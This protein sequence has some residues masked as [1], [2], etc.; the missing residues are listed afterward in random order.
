MSPRSNDSNASS[1]KQKKKQ[2]HS[3]APAPSVSLLDSSSSSSPDALLSDLDSTPASNQPSPDKNARVA[4][5]ASASTAPRVFVASTLKPVSAIDSVTSTISALSHHANRGISNLIAAHSISNNPASPLIAPTAAADQLATPLRTDGSVSPIYDAFHNA[6]STPDPAHIEAA[7]H[8]AQSSQPPPPRVLWSRWDR[9]PLKSH[10]LKFAPLLISYYD[11]GS[12]QALL[13]QDRTMSE[14]L[15]LPNA[16]DVL[17]DRPASVSALARPQILTA[18]VRPPSANTSDPQ[19]L[20]V[21][22]EPDDATCLLAYALTSH[23][24]QASVQLQ[25]HSVSLLQAT[26]QHEP[27]RNVLW[28]HVQAQCNQDYLV[29]SFAAPA[30]IHVLSP[31]TLEYLRSPILEVAAAST[32]RP[33]PVSLSHRLLAF[34]CAASKD[35]SPIR[36]D[37]RKVSNPAYHDPTR[38]SFAAMPSDASPRV[39]EMRDNL[40]ETSAHMGDAARR[41]RGGVMS[42]VRTLGEWG[43][44]YWPQ[45]GSPPA[46][47]AA[48]SPPQSSLLSQSAPH[49][50]SHLPRQASSAS[51]SPMLLAADG[52]RAAKRLSTGAPA[53]ANDA[54]AGS[55]QGSHTV[56]AA[57]VRVID[58]ASDARTICTFAPSNHAVTLVAFSPCGRLILTADTLGHAFHVFELPLS[59][60][61]GSA[62]A[63][64]SSSP[65]LHRYKL[66]RGITTAD[67]V[68]AQWTPDAQ[69]VAVG[70]HSG[71]VHIY[72]V[73]PFGGIPSIANHVQAKI[74][75][76]HAPQ[77][78]GLSLPSL[79]RSVR[80]SAP[81]Q[82]EVPQK[83]TSG[84]APDAHVATATDMQ[85]KM[86]PPSFLL[87][88]RALRAS[89]SDGDASSPFELLTSDPRSVSVTLH[90]IRC[91][92][93]QTRASSGSI[94]SEDV[95]VDS[96]HHLVAATSPRASGLS[97]MMRKAGEGLLPNQQAPRLQAECVRVALWDQLSPDAGSFTK[98]SVAPL[99]DQTS[100]SF[101]S[102]RS[103]VSLAKSLTSVAKA[104][105]ETYSQSPAMLPSSIFLSRQ[106]FF[107]ARTRSTK[108]TSAATGTTDSLRCIQRRGS[109]PI[110]VR[111]TARIV[112]REP[113]SENASSFDDSLA[114]AL[115]QMSFNPENLPPRSASAHIPSFPQGQRG[116]SAGWTAGSSIPIRIVAGGLGGIY[117]AGKELGRGVDIARRRTSGASGTAPP[118]GSGASVVGN[119]ASISFDAVDDVDLLGEDEDAERSSRHRY[120]A[121]HSAG[122]HMEQGSAR[123]DLSMLS[124]LRNDEPSKGSQPSSAETPSTRFSEAEDVDEC[125]WDAI[126]EC[127][128]PAAPA[129]PLF[130]EVDT[131]NKQVSH[132]VSGTQ[133]SNSMDDDFTVGMLDE[134]SDQATMI[135]SQS[136]SQSGL[137]SVQD[138]KAKANAPKELVYA[139]PAGGSTRSSL[140]SQSSGMTT[141]T[142]DNRP[143]AKAVLSNVRDSSPSDSDGGDTGSQRSAGSGMLCEG[144]KE[145]HTFDSAQELDASTKEIDAKADKVVAAKPI[146]TLG[147][148]GKKKKGGR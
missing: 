28:P 48:F 134:D 50:A 123:S 25:H 141:T 114:G 14:L 23:Q 58:L 95:H 70:T 143:E 9:L 3:P 126:E 80:P 44:S 96:K 7:I 29:L 51:S 140:L 131:R 33:P 77:P 55:S 16:A 85:T 75:N 102:D 110:Q 113:S 130:D 34:A 120:R 92:S 52:G 32:E 86:A 87:L 71:T 57:C 64:S 43:S 13:L 118:E 91:W 144:S 112:S 47:S 17:L 72:A 12:L 73:N 78:F 138:V 31:S 41:I 53:A 35:V 82:Q 100:A 137:S 97:Q 59:G 105:I 125:D 146:S 60:T 37:S 74:R 124:A 117:R 101:H 127:R 65:V 22:Q 99:G 67:V 94:G 11:N 8:N 121:H 119:T 36:S 68:H 69:W 104:E 20:L 128:S 147:G 66:M 107:H 132:G 98:H 27:R 56:Y 15:S 135:H 21:V 109:R 18:L 148:G 24:V 136:R 10:S 45:A 83:P 6:G 90:T 106:T 1:T 142:V 19:L 122:G 103:Q 46:T 111:R 81:P 139:L 88:N 115:D 108:A 4:S 40:F 38:S 62:A 2:N 54:A 93:T 116:R 145:T 63:T 79:A 84:L 42:G 133:G 26:Q 76:P 89:L 5:A 129:A 61:F 39:G 30:S 49:T